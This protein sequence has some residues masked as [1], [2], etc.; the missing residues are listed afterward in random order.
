M[1]YPFLSA[2]PR[3]VLATFTAHGSPV[4]GSSGSQAGVPL[5]QEDTTIA[6][7]HPRHL[8]SL[9][10][11]RSGPPAPLR[12]V[13]GFPSCRLLR[14]LRRLGARARQA[15]PLSRLGRQTA[16]LRCSVRPVRPSVL[17]AAPPCG[18]FPRSFGETSYPGVLG[19]DVIRGVRL[20]T[21]GDWSSVNPDFTISCGSCGTASYTS[22][23][24]YRFDGMLQFP[25]AFAAR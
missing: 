21:A 23:G 20:C 25:L 12:P 9:S 22:S 16:R 24:V 3:T 1:A 7:P 2:P 18:S 19:S 4:A 10:P 17:R 15:I 5:S 8:A 13:A 6:E 11:Y 14:G